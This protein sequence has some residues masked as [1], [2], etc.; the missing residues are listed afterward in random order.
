MFKLLSYAITVPHKAQSKVITSS[1][2]IMSTYTR[3]LFTQGIK[4]HLLSCDNS[5][6]VLGNLGIS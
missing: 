6:V 3:V 1:L 2:N 4:C 5:L